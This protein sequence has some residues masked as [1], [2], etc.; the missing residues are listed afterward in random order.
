MEEKQDQIKV[1]ASLFVEKSIL[2]LLWPSLVFYR[3]CRIL[4][5]TLGVLFFV[6]QAL[7]AIVHLELA[8]YI[9]HYGLR[10]RLI[11]TNKFESTKSHHSWNSSEKS[12]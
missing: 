8:N 9:E 3:I 10:R 6:I 2:A 4:W 12:K 11:D 5:V 1:N 7:V